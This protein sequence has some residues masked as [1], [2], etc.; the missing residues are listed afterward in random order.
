MWRSWMIVGVGV[1]MLVTTSA[2][3]RHHA[4][5]S[6]PT[7][8]VAAPEPAAMP[9]AA[10]SGFHPQEPYTAALLVDRDSGQVLFA[11]NEHLRWPPASMTKM[12][13]VLIAM[14]QV[15]DHTLSLD[16]TITA[17]KWASKIGGS[18]V[19]LSEGE[20]FPLRDL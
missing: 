20:Q 18:Q 3:A 19:Y 7:V 13:T 1:A 12:M 4:A 6:R 2:E 14:E 15:R 17:S 8:P 16:E 10:T 11:K 9:P 5:A